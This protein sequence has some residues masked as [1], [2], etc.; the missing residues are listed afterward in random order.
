MKY[1]RSSGRHYDTTVIEKGKKSLG[2]QANTYFTMCLD[3]LNPH[4][5]DFDDAKLGINMAFEELYEESYAA[6]FEKAKIRNVWN[7]KKSLKKLKEFD[8]VNAKKIRIADEIKIDVLNN[9][10]CKYTERLLHLEKLLEIFNTD[11]FDDTSSK[12]NRGMNWIKKTFTKTKEE[13]GRRRIQPK[14]NKKQRRK[15]SKKSKTY[16]N[17]TSQKQPQRK[18]QNVN[19]RRR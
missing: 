12:Y 10:E 18:R 13:G 15:Q 9:L 16:L 7:I 3:N 17:I 2:Y 19:T 11:N 5:D 8:A 4:R 1:W 6:P 14:S